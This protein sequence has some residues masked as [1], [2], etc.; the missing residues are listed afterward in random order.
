MIG[1]PEWFKRRKYSGWGFTPAT[2]QGWVYILVM[3]VPIIVISNLKMPGDTQIV[4]L[5]IWALIFCVDFVDIIIHLKKDERDRIHE[6]I[7]ERNALW[8]VLAVMVAGLAYQVAS[9]VVTKSI[10]KVD[11]VI[12]IALFAALIAKIITNVYLDKKD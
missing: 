8:V 12:L 2:W 9:D 7:A 1:K 11:P 3:I 4:F 5:V 10:T 6:A